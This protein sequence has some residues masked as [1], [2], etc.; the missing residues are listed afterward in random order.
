LVFTVREEYGPDFE[1]A[2][3]WILQS[4]GQE[5]AL[6]NRMVC[7]LIRRS[8]GR[9]TFNRGWP[10]QPGTTSWVEPTALSIVALRRAASRFQNSE[11]RIRVREGEALLL[12]LRTN[13]GGWNYGNASVLGVD[14]P[15]YPETTAVAL[16]GLQHRLPA[17]IRPGASQSRLANAWQAIARMSLGQGGPLETIRESPEDLMVA[18]LEA[19]ASPGGNAHVFKTEAIL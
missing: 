8:N 14:L 5:N 13:D 16:L 12:T 1:R 10:W 4:A 6:V 15:S 2:I 3:R 17:G 19:I 7:R 9:D 18:A 11:L